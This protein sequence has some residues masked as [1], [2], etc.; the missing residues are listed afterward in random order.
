MTSSLRPPWIRRW[1]VVAGVFAAALVPAPGALAAVG[2]DN[3]GNGPALLFSVPGTVA[4]N[5]G[6][7]VQGGEPVAAVAGCHSVP[8]TRTAWWRFTG[9]GQPIKLTTLASNFDTV[10]AVYD[11]PAGTPISGNRVACN[12]DDPGAGGGVTSALTFSSTRGKSYLVQVGSRGADHGRIDLKASSARP[13]N[14][15][16]IS[17]RVLQTG[18]AATVSNVGASQ[19]LGERLTCATDNYAATIW[20]AW[21]APAVGDAVF[22]SSAAFGDTVATVYRAR[23]GAVLG[24][25]TASTTR[26][27]LRVSPGAYLVQVGTKGS[28]V[29]GLG[30]GSITTKAD[31]AV[32]ADLDN[33]GALGSSDCDDG[34]PA[35]RPGVLDVPEDGVDQDCVGGDAVNFDRDRDGFTRPGDCRDDLAGVHPGARDVPRNRVDEDCRDGD[36]RFPNLPTS[37]SIQYGGAR[38]GVR[39]T[40]LVLTQVLAGSRVRIL[41]SGRSG[42]SKSARRS[43]RACRPH[44]FERRYQRA[45][46]RVKLT[47]V[48]R[49]A[50]LRRGAVLEVR[51]TKPEMLGRVRRDRVRRRRVDPRRLCLD[52]RRVG[53]RVGSVNRKIRPRKERRGEE[54]S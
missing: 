18:A 40:S 47:R 44:R 34:N 7:S 3:Y 20:F 30:V 38:R 39:V 32:D 11:A 42:R 50:R 16:R 52:P 12:D 45:H 35:I 4:D 19:E 51:V 14:D 22:T 54:C 25:N 53:E 37:I 9:T 43:R 2:A 10:L 8:M 29:D 46:K 1:L 21:T 27:P 48:M 31:F 17:A 23:D 33:D 26:V 24:C 36:G 41:C 49:R 5:V 13:A 15:D 6:Y 28:N